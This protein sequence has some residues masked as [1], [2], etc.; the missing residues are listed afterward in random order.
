MRLSLHSTTGLRGFLRTPQRVGR[1]AGAGRWAAGRAAATAAVVAGAFVAKRV[2]R[3]IMLVFMSELRFGVNKKVFGIWFPLICSEF[4]LHGIDVIAEAE[5]R[6][7][8]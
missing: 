8:L 3:V 7:A 6:R 1:A 5:T 2:L 4:R